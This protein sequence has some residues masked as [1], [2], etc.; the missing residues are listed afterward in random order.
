MNDFLPL[1]GSDKQTGVIITY[2]RESF[3]ADRQQTAESRSVVLHVSRRL[4][5]HSARSARVVTRVPG[6]KILVSPKRFLAPSERGVLGASLGKE[7]TLAVTP[8]L[9]SRARGS[10]RSHH[11]GEDY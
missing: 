9:L 8:P 4:A 2:L 6:P 7:A 11:P 10:C 3:G 5:V 1:L